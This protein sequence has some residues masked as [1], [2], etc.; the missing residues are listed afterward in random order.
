MSINRSGCYYSLA[1]VFFQAK[2]EHN[3]QLVSIMQQPLNISSRI[4]VSKKSRKSLEKGLTDATT[5]R[6]CI[7]FFSNKNH[8]LKLSQMY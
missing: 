7:A 8:W 3:D 2:I 6:V 5:L 1:R 4:F